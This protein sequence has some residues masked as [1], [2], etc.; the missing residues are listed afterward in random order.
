M[1]KIR[2]FPYLAGLAAAAAF[3]AL[4]FFLF[5]PALNA[6][7]PVL[8]ILSDAALFLFI[9]VARLVK[10]TRDFGREKEGRLKEKTERNDPVPF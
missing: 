1:K 10:G 7:D 4:S 9:L 2:V 5:C 6:H 3:S 8:W